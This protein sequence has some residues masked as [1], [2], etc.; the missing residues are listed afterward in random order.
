MVS[1]NFA[2]I[3]H[4]WAHKISNMYW[5]LKAVKSQKLISRRFFTEKQRKATS[6]KGAI[7]TTG[8]KTQSCSFSEAHVES[9]DWVTLVSD[10][11]RG[12]GCW[13][14]IAELTKAFFLSHTIHL[15]IY[16]ELVQRDFSAMTIATITTSISHI[17]AEKKVE[18]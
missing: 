3:A 16:K 11:P 9:E 8:I 12:G 14:A 4:I 5:S 13:S 15:S 6:R 1:S 10:H 7:L 17:T 18:T 2:A